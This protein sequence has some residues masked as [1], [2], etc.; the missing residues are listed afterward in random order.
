[1]ELKRNR[2]FRVAALTLIPSFLFVSVIPAKTL[3]Y[4]VSSGEFYGPAVSQSVRVADMDKIQRVLESR[5]ISERLK[6]LGL[7]EEEINTRLSKLTD[8]ELHQFATQ[9]DSLYPGGNGLGI[10]I[11]ILVI[12]LLVIVILKVMDKKIIIE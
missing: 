10:V 12:I 5:I 7:S 3:A 11:A 1:M 4:V 8:E 2:F 9:V 6:G